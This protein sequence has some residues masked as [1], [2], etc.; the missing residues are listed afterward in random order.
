MTGH[1]TRWLSARAAE[2]REALD[3]LWSCIGGEGTLQLASETI[4]VATDNHTRLH[5]PD[6]P[7]AR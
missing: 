7:E 1:H 5:H 2:L 6:H 4:R 3:D